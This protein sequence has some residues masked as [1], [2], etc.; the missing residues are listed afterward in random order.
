MARAAAAA[1]PIAENDD[2]NIS[3]TSYAESV[4]ELEGFTRA[5]FVEL[6][7]FNNPPDEVKFCLFAVLVLMGEKKP[8]WQK[9]KVMLKDPSRFVKQCKGYDIDKVDPRILKKVKAY[10]TQD[11][12]TV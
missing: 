8:D 4:R 6:K 12:F 3:L 9:A 10:V 7:A 5:D 11:F 1:N 2:D